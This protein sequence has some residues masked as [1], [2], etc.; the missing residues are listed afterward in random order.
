MTED[1]LDAEAA[2]MKSLLIRLQ[3]EVTGWMRPPPGGPFQP[4]V[5][6][7]YRNPDLGE[8]YQVRVAQK[9]G[10][11]HGYWRREMGRYF[12][13]P[14]PG[15]APLIVA[16]TEYEAVAHTRGHCVRRTGLKG[17][18][19]A[20]QAHSNPDGLSIL[21]LDVETDEAV[22]VFVYA[23]ALHGTLDSYQGINDPSHHMGVLQQHRQRIER[24]A[25][26]KYVKEG[27][28][29]ELGGKPALWVQPSD[30]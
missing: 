7:K 16:D 28:I 27:V 9:G 24:A 11:V 29:G 20:P 22:R 10:K 6:E 12:F 23:P 19:S 26:D 17:T 3:K 4:F 25:S 18:G 21:M 8:P 15:G 14:Q 2:V 30:L 13:S 1:E 5:V